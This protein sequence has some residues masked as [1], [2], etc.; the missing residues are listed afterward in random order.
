M[1]TKIWGCI[2]GAVMFASALQSCQTQVEIPDGAVYPILFG[3]T[4]TRAVANLDDLKTNGFKVYAYFKGTQ[5][6]YGSGA[7]EKD[8]R[9]EDSY[10]KYDN[11]EYWIPNTTYNFKAFYPKPTDMTACTS[12]SFTNGA[13]QS[14][15][16]SDFDIS[17]QEDFMVATDTRS[18]NAN[19]EPDGS[20]SVV[21]LNFKHQLALVEIKIKSAISVTIKNITLNNI[22]TGYQCID[23]VWSQGDDGNKTDFVYVSNTKLTPGADYADVTG[24]GIL[25]IPSMTYS[26][27]FTIEASNKTYSEISLP[28]DTVWEKGRKYTY[29]MEIKQNDIIFN[30]PKVEIWDSESATGSVIIK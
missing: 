3:S 4:E 22:A 18:V 13:E 2:L 5:E 11:L 7:F 29:T 30:E 26:E 15:T 16:V 23:G 1:K 12:F 9:F 28:A 19:A 6:G 10:W 27:T 20:S 25:V 17:K 21:T 24:G 8:V 14:Y